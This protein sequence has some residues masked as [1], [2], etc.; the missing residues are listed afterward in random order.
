MNERNKK[1]SS[2]LCLLALFCFC[3]V[4]FSYF[5]S[6]KNQIRVLEQLLA[7]S[8]ETEKLHLEEKR[9]LREEMNF[10][11]KTLSEQQQTSAL[12]LHLNAPSPTPKLSSPSSPL[13]PPR[14]RGEEEG[15]GAGGGAGGGGEVFWVCYGGKKAKVGVEA[16]TDVDDLR[17]VVCKMFLL[18]NPALFDVVQVLIFRGCF[19]LRTKQ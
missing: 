4:S 14:V 8:E 15:A 11:R 5:P 17:A 13:P 3:C 16:G 19:P 2:F 10:L 7:E 18:D 1:G 12:H 6:E 9:I